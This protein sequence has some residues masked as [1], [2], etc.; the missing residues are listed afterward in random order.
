MADGARGGG[1]RRRDRGVLRA[2][3]AGATGRSHRGLGQ[4]RG[5][6]GPIQ[7]QDW[8]PGRCAARVGRRRGAWRPDHRTTRSRRT[9]SAGRSAASGGPR[10]RRRSR[11]TR[12][13]LTARGDL[14]GRS[15]P[16]PGQSRRG[17]VARRGGAPGGP[18]QAGH[19]VGTGTG[20]GAC[21]VGGGARAC[22]RRGG[23][24]RAPAQRSA[25]GARCAGPCTARTREA[26]A[27]SVADATRRCAARRAD[28]R[29][30]PVGK[31]RAR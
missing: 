8:R 6:R 30:R 3:A 19:R 25:A 24:S 29:D 27:R 13:W 17:A 2:V 11:G 20:S 5:H 28:F 16:G 9:G 31:R 22:P 1:G 21:R 12:G 10:R 18:L 15:R 14:A 4:H 7:F 23:A 26:G